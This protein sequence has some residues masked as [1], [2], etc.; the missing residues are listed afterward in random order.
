MIKNNIFLLLVIGIFFCGSLSFGSPAKQVSSLADQ[1]LAKAIS[2]EGILEEPAEGI[3]NRDKEKFLETVSLKPQE[4]TWCHAANT[5]LVYIPSRR[6]KAMSG[7]I[8]IIESGFEYSYEFKLFGQLPVTFSLENE[9]IGINNTTALDLPA[10]LV[11]I[12]AGIE[13]ILPF[14][15]FDKTYLNLGVN[16]S[17][18]SDS[19]T[20]RSSA[21]RLPSDIF[22]IYTP[23]E[24]ITL[25]AGAA[26][27][28]DF[29]NAVLPVIGCI[30]KP[31]EKFS[32]EMTSDA[33]N[34]TYSP[35]KRIDLF[36]EIDSPVV[37][38]YEVKRGRSNGVVLTYNEMLVGL[39]AK[40]KIN[41]Y[42]KS[43]LIVGGA[44]DRYIRY[45]DED[46]KV[47]IKNGLYTEVRVDV[48][49]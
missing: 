21:F 16:P 46:G 7:G 23:K 34:I 44:F 24:Q 45:R 19:Y 35:N 12:S 49:I 14:F 15:Y 39:G 11:G 32:L 22:L 6:S 48:E 41:K 40:Y 30:Y 5:Y 8:E 9:Y 17:F 33:S 10:K 43:S 37:S 29:K 2:S 3:F 4:K 42:I 38:E 31:N 28:P 20:F 27:C 26:V 1:N 25:I 18:Y 13:T 47:S 36:L